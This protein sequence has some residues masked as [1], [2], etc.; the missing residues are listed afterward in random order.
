MVSIAKAQSRSP[1]PVFSLLS[2]YLRP[3]FFF[4]FFSASLLRYHSLPIS[5]SESVVS[6]SCFE[7]EVRVRKVETRLRCF[8]SVPA[9]PELRRHPAP[10]DLKAGFKW[11]DFTDPFHS[12]SNLLEK[13]IKPR[14]SQFATLGICWFGITS[15]IKQVRL[16]S[17]KRI[18]LVLSS[19]V[20]QQEL[21]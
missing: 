19:N 21:N 13:Q 17:E 6:A 2:L 8:R 3:C 12:L 5:Q 15:E 9:C 16:L 4:F 10:G 1:S 7:R 20:S 14:K 18:K 11:S